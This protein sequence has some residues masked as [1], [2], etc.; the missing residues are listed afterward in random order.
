[1]VNRVKFDKIRSQKFQREHKIDSQNTR[2]NYKLVMEMDSQRQYISF[3][4]R[5]YV[6]SKNCFVDHRRIKMIKISA[7]FGT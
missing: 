3:S 5:A 1:M 4:C 6:D 2:R 7:K